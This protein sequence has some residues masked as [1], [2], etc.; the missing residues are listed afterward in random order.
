MVWTKLK[1]EKENS[2]KCWITYCPKRKSF[3]WC[4]AFATV[5]NL[6]P[7]AQLSGLSFFFLCCSTFSFT[8]YDVN[9]FLLLPFFGFT[10]KIWITWAK[11]WMNGY[12]TAINKVRRIKKKLAIITQWNGRLSFC[13]R[14]WFFLK[15]KTELLSCSIRACKQNDT[16]HGQFAFTCF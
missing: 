2:L 6:L 16:A 13:V 4:G 9:V 3:R 12:E 7:L 1:V 10:C 11:Y 15:T 14:V 8:H 5:S